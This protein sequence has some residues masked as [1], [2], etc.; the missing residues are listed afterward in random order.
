MKKFK[1]T[2]YS[3]SKSRKKKNYIKTPKKLLS[4]LSIRNKLIFT[5]ILLCSIPLI[6]TSIFIYNNAERS[7]EEKVGLY[8]RKMVEQ[9]VVNL[10]SKF[11]E[12]ES[13]STMINS[14][15]DIL[16][17]LEKEKYES[18]SDELND[19]K[20]IKRTMSSVNSTNNNIKGIYIYTSNDVT[21]GSGVDLSI[22]D[23][24]INKEDIRNQ[25]KEIAKESDG[26]PVWIT[27]FNDSYDYIILARP[28]YNPTT[29]NYLGVLTIFLDNKEIQSILERTDMDKTSDILLLNENGKT[30]THLDED[31]LGTEFTDEY[32]DVIYNDDSYDTLTDSSYV[33]SYGTTQNKWKIVT[34]ESK[35]FLMKEMDNIKTNTVIGV[36][37]SVIFSI[38]LGIIIAFSISKPLR[39]IMKLM[40]QVEQGDL[41]IS[42]D[43]K[44]KNEIGRLSSSFNKM[45]ENVRHLIMQSNN[46][47][48][49][50][51]K[52]TTIIN[53]SS[54]ESAAAA[55]QVTQ[56]ITELAE[57]S[58]EQAKQAE[59]T[60]ELMN[61]L[62]NNINQ[63]IKRIKNIMD[64][65][66]QTQ[67]SREQ[68]TNTITILNEKTNIAVQSTNDINDEIN[69]LYD[70]TKE[71][72]S[73]VNVIA[74]ISEQ[75][76]LLALNAAIEAARAGE[77]GKGFA[78]VADEI[79]K[80][81][82]QT[83]DATEMIS[84]IISTIQ[85]K[86]KR[87]VAI[88]QSSDKIFEEQKSMVHQTNT[89]FNEMS[90]F[91]QKV[92]NQI[93]DINMMIKDIEQHKNQSVDAMSNI[94]AIV[95]EASSSIEEVTAT[96]EEQ[97]SSAEQL[98][99]LSNN[100]SEVIE[101]L[102]KSI[103]QFKI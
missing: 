8:S 84:K 79:R 27:G 75:T 1:A 61:S 56:A 69:K 34:K 6:L 66:E 98:A 70:E 100:L 18:S 57:G 48:T 88:A 101:E 49:E 54:K 2:S 25:F 47:T 28:L 31:R 65:I 93:E 41:T 58:S 59:N 19:V 11:S 17:I 37:I 15:N 46:V 62:A 35:S 64:S 33:V 99:T 14:N 29:N 24:D 43:I 10:D 39:R 97:T 23:N 13:I 7:V 102:K 20:I 21:Y 94:S 95:E 78:V 36:L 22:L 51:E 53:Q 81:A 63:V 92:I 30:I 44:G 52:N 76:N 80:L 4:N 86:T 45:I 103:S 82:M 72:I 73:V 55:S 3:K 74:S 38:F 50:V 87:T 16:K 26:K 60:T 90:E 5:L 9:I 91:M 12:L 89:A 83:K 85:N 67:I 40:G 32:I 77:A 96:S 68:A 42:C 71:I